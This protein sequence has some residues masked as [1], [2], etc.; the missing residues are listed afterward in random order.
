MNDLCKYLEWDSRF[1]GLNIARCQPTTLN[2]EQMPLILGWCGQNQIDCL[3]FLSEC[4]DSQTVKLVEKHG[5]HL[6]DI[7]LTLEKR[8]N[9]PPPDPQDT[10]IRLCQTADIPFLRNIASHSFTESR[11]YYDGRFLKEHCDELYATWIEKSCSGYADSVWVIEVQGQP[12]GFISCH[13][14]PDD[15][16]GQIGLFGIDG[17][18]RGQGLGTRLIQQALHWFHQQGLQH[19]EVVT[20]GR[21]IAAQRAYQQAGFRTSAVQLWYH[22][23]FSK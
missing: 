14:Y 23:W 10:E 7:R 3:Y 4:D 15:G 2:S 16:R 6:V 17:T 19:V 11:F 18:A 22:R 9:S 1:F 12:A 20:Q 8:F 5:F 13:C 21:S